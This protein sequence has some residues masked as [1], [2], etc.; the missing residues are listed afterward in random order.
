MASIFMIDADIS[1]LLFKSRTKSI[2]EL[3][4][5]TDHFLSKHFIFNAVYI[6][7]AMHFHWAVD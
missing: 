5:E 7:L 3:I 4:L 2:S 1:E 6:D